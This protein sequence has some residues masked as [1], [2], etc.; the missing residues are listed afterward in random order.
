MAEPN[1]P[2]YYNSGIASYNS[3]ISTLAMEKEAE[4]GEDALEKSKCATS[5]VAI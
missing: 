2:I 1:T 3:G 4:V 5:N